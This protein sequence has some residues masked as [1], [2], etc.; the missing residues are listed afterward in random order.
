MQGAVAAHGHHAAGKRVGIDHHRLAVGDH[1]VVHPAYKQVVVL[2]G[3][4]RLRFVAADVHHRQLVRLL[5]AQPVDDVEGEVEALGVLEGDLLQIAAAVLGNAD[6]VFPDAVLAGDAA[7]RD[8]RG[9]LGH[10]GGLVAGVEHDGVKVAVLAVG[11]QQAVGRGGVIVDRVAGAEDLGVIAQLDLQMAADDDVQLLAFVCGCLHRMELSVGV[12]YAVDEQRLGHTSAEFVRQSV[13]GHA[14][15]VVD[16]AALPG[17]GEDVAA[18]TRRHALDKLAHVYGE[19]LGYRVQEAE[20]QLFPARLVVDIVVLGHAQPAGHVRFGEAFDLAQFA[21][22]V[23]DFVD[24]VL[25]FVR[26]VHSI[27][28]RLMPYL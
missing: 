6:E 16:D 15:G 20:V 3:E 22:T 10:D 11:G 25:K 14:V 8:D 7:G 28:P 21:D 1:E 9:K 26:S 24:L 27:L 12:E 5:P 19:D 18:Q 17:A 13:I 2:E 4:A 23:D